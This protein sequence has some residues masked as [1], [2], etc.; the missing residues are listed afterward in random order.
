MILEGLATGGPQRTSSGMRGAEAALESSH[1][2]RRS[3]PW[4]AKK[5]SLKSEVTAEASMRSVPM[6]TPGRSFPAEPYRISL[7][8]T[9]G[10]V[11]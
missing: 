6:R 9:D 10:A 4:S 2:R 5:D 3:M 11:A 7:M 8:R 1:A